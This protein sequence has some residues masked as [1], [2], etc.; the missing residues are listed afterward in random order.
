MNIAIVNDYNEFNR[1][2]DSWNNLLES[3]D[4]DSVFLTHEW[5]SSFIMA[6]NLEKKLSIILIYDNSDFVG[7]LPL[8][9][10]HVKYGF[11]NACILK[12]ISNVHT[13]K[14]SFIIKSGWEDSLGKVLTI[15]RQLIKWDLIQ[16][17]YVSQNSFMIKDFSLMNQKWPFRTKIVLNMKSPH[18]KINCDWDTYYNKHFDKSLRKNIE[19]SIRK[20]QRSF[21]VSFE[22]IKGDRLT[23]DDLED[24]FMIEDS[25]WKGRNGSSIVKNDSFRKFYEQLAIETNRHGWFA[26]RFL[27]FDKKRVAFDYFLK[28]KYCDNPLKTGYCEEYKKYSPGFILRKNT[29][30]DAFVNEYKIYD[31]LGTSDDYKLKMANGVESLYS[32]YFFNKQVVSRLLKFIFFDAKEIAEKMGIKKYLKKIYHKLKRR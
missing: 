2:H 3:S 23:Q 25:G 5:F 21:H 24:A 27:K 1:L 19:K 30:I 26:L 7:I 18:I 17:D 31:L 4:F 9:V 32:V 11:I 10:E 15:A 6:F 13:P 12:S 8:Y 16:T 22:T 20:A 28:Y 14:Y 29:I